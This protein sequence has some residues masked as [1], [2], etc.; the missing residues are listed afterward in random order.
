MAMFVFA[1]Q[2]RTRVFVFTCAGLCKVRRRV[3]GS[4]GHGTDG[5][6]AAFVAGAAFGSSHSG[7]FPRRH[8]TSRHR[9]VG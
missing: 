5:D 8:P 9:V 4:D 3:C 2:L 6:T 1:P 7:G